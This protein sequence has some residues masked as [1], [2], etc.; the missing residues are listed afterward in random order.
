[1]RK[2]KL[3]FSLLIS[4]TIYHASAQET[5]MNDISE[6]YIARLVA[7]AE[8]NYPQV[9]ANQNQVNIALAN[10]GKA[11]MSYLEAITFSYIYQPNGYN[12][13][14]SQSGGTTANLSTF[15]GVQAGLFFNLGSFLEK[16]YAVKEARQQLEIASNTQDQYYLTL[17]NMVKKRYYTYIGD[18]AMLKFATQATINAETVTN[19]I[20]QKNQCYN[21]VFHT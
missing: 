2:L 7:R 1:M 16:P 20:K 8:A 19:D 11:K 14:G 13:A 6:D 15:N 5:I 10:V 21:H 3:L 12:S 17:T 18:I 9:K 4:L